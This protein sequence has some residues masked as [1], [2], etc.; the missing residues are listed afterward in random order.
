M[1]DYQVHIRFT[2]D[3]YYEIH[4]AVSIQ[5]AEQLALTRVHEDYPLAFRPEVVESQEVPPQEEP[6]SNA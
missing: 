5:L 6:P 4:K 3:V 2:N 1:P